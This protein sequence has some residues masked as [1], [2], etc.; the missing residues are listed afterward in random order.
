[1]KDHHLPM[2]LLWT[3]S[4]WEQRLRKEN[5]L[6]ELF[7]DQAKFSASLLTTSAAGALLRDE[8]CGIIEE[9]GNIGQ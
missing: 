4:S 9:V 5:L 7:E 1:M 6:D 2:D 8:K 3:S